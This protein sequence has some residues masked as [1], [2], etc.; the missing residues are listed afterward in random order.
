[1]TEVMDNPVTEIQQHQIADLSIVKA[2]VAVPRFMP[3][4][5]RALG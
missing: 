3:S 1:M 4:G 5:T 2:I